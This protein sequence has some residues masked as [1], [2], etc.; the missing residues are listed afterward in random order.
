MAHQYPFRGRLIVWLVPSALIAAAAGAEWIR[1]RVSVLHPPVG[2]ALGAA[3]I[4]AFLVPPVMALGQMP[5][6]YDV[7]HW[8]S[9]LSYLQSH[10]QAAMRYMCLRCSASE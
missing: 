10:R 2:S 9:I 6:P 3:L 8:R 1:G 5:P 7:E 4:I